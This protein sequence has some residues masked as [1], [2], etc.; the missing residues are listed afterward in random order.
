MLRDSSPIFDNPELPSLRRT[1]PLPKRRRTS[2]SSSRDDAGSIMDPPDMPLHDATHDSADALVS[3]N[4]LLALQS[5]Y[6]PILGGMQD[7]LKTET[8]GGIFG[9]REHAGTGSLFSTLRSGRGREEDAVVEGDYLDHFQQ[10]GNT[11]K[12]KVPANL[13][14]NGP[15]QDSGGGSE[16]DDEPTDRAIPTGRPDHEYDAA[17]TANGF[18]PGTFHQRKNRMSRATVAGLQHKEMLKSR[19]RQLAVVLGALTHGDTLAMDQALSANNYPFT[20]GS[21]APEYHSQDYPK[22]RLSRRPAARVARVFKASQAKLRPSDDPRPV[23]SSDFTFT[24]HSASKCF[25]TF[26]FCVTVRSF[27][28]LLLQPPIALW[29]R[30]RK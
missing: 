12:R 26:F 23:P 14:V 6:M 24:F 28:V 15:G 8:E 5:Y 17:G 30:R 1:K 20:S 27:G 10:P 19:K 22:T 29:Q 4:S 18:G 13:A 25:C 11:K 3:S 7:L 9:G 21:L 2:E 16:G